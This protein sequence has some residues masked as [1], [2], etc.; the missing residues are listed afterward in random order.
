L[1]DGGRRQLSLLYAVGVTRSTPYGVGR[2]RAV[3]VVLDVEITGYPVGL[4]LVVDVCC[5]PPVDRV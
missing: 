4:R 2:S 1:F 3:S 5:P